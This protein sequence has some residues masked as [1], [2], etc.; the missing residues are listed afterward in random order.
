MLSSTL[1][2]LL[3]SVFFV[4]GHL[5][6]DDRTTRRPRK[7]DPE[8]W[9][10]QDRQQRS[11]NSQYK[12]KVLDFSADNDG[13]FDC[14]PDCHF[15]SKYE[16]TSANLTAGLLPESFTVCSAIMVEAWTG[17]FHSADMFTLF[18]DDEYQWG[19][20]RLDA[21]SSYTQYDVKLGRPS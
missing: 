17:E 10:I 15:N 6:T 13:E 16:F 3:L 5:L 1:F 21:A 9:S 12:L 11:D 20:I 2:C 7:G 4:S 19:M 14:H 18:D 8:K